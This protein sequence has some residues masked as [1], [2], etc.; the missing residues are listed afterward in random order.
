[1]RRR[2]ARRSLLEFTRYTKP[3]YEVSWHHRLICQRLDALLRGEIR[4]LMVFAPPRHGKS[5]LISRRLPAYYLGRDPDASIIACSYSAELAARMNRDVQRIIDDPAYARLFPATRLWSSQV[6]TVA[7]PG[8][9]LRNSDLFEIVNH[10]GVYR[11]AG[12]GGGITGMGATLGIIDDPIKNE[13]EAYSATVRRNVLDWYKSTF[14]TRL[15]KDSRIVLIMTRWHRGDLAGAL[16]EEAAATPDA[17]Q[18]EVLSFPA[19]AQ[20]GGH[21]T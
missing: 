21:G 11:A 1:M 2:K 6:R 10:R 8:T 15:E 12:V 18:W 16:L 4:R 9:W 19:L 5:E 13:E 7:K 14:Y 17:D 20:G 3:D